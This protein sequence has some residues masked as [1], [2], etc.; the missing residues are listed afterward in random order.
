MVVDDTLNC[1]HFSFYHVY[2]ILFRFLCVYVHAYRFETMEN[3]VDENEEHY[4]R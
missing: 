2:D 1:F 3:K 4:K